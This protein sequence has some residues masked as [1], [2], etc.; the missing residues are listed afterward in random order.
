MTPEAQRIAIAEAR[1]WLVFTRVAEN[2]ESHGFPPKGW[3][4]TTKCSA[5]QSNRLAYY[6]PDYLNDLNAMHEAE[7]IFG[8]TIEKT[9]YME[10]ILF[11][12]NTDPAGDGSWHEQWDVCHA[13][14]AQR[15]EAFLCTIGKWDDSK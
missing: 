15:A 3:K 4:P 6:L 2:G 7:N 14:A 9:A 11:T 13:T 5:Y 12:M 8:T 1:G 10:N